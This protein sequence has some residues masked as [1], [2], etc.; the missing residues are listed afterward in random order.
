MIGKTDWTQYL[1]VIRKREVDIVFS[2]LPQTHFSSGLEIGAGD[3]FQTTLIA[4]HVDKLISSD[5]NFKRIKESLKVPGVLYKAVDADA[6]EGVFKPNTFD[7]IFS[8]NVLEHVR[9]PQKVLEE[10]EK[11]LTDDGYAVH[12]IPSRHIKVSYLLLYYPNLAILLLD[13]II[14]KLKGE[15]IF[16]GIGVNFENNI[17]IKVQPKK[18]SGRLRRLLV[19]TPHGNFSSHVEEFI[20]FGKKQWERKFIEAGYSIVTYAKGP[21]FSGYGFGFDRLRKL[22][23]RFGLSSEHIFVL[24]KMSQ[25][26]ADSWAYTKKYLSHG[27]FR[28]Q[29]KFVKDWLNKDKSAKAFFN[30]FMSAVGNPHGKK[31]LDIGFGNGIMARE[32]IKAGAIVYG[33][34]TEEELVNLSKNPNMRLYDGRKFPFDQASFNYAYSTS[35]L[36]HMS[37]P[38]EVIKEVGRT[39]KP[40]GKFYLSFPNRY[41]PRETHT[42]IW[43]ISWLPRFKSSRLEDWNLHF[44]SFFALRKMAKRAGLRIVYDTHSHSFIRRSIKK[45]LAQFGVHYGVLLKT[46]IVILEKPINYG[47]L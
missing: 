5:L 18:V 15:P 23:E 36:E 7:F 47:K 41:A 16:Q 30:D 21:A 27:S 38:E 45:I 37:Y 10:T 35:V 39:L 8:S 26:E 2:L 12:I 14:G 11:L 24:K 9:N 46:I 6:V 34:E 3:G 44:V 19:P 25:F 42:G 33:L 13:R 17:N 29:R 22:L 4:P 43:F 32:F 1:H 28:D 40:G 31:V 20:A